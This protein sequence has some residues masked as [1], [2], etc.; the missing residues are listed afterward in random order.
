MWPPTATTRPPLYRDVYT[1]G[2]VPAVHMGARASAVDVV[3]RKS[4]ALQAAITNLTLLDKKVQEFVDASK[5]Q[6]QQQRQG[7]ASALSAPRRAASRGPSPQPPSGQLWVMNEHGQ[8]QPLHVSMEEVIGHGRPQPAP[9]LPPP[10][11]DY[12]QPVVP[13]STPP[14]PALAPPAERRKLSN[15]TA[16]PPFGG[17]PSRAAEPQPLLPPPQPPADAEPDGSST[18][19]DSPASGGRDRGRG[20]HSPAA[21]PRGKLHALEHLLADDIDVEDMLRELELRW[22]PAATS[23][24]PSV[25]V[26]VC[27]RGCDWL[28]V[29]AQ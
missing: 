26:A 25:C 4:Q 18:D 2:Q 29:W 5:Q 1:H 27:V 28:A 14:V 7:R 22:P 15:T 6:Q 17:K 8:L 19:S 3:R 21:V 11:S 13:P 20:G 23:L 12:P 10:R 16:V 9:Q 24:S